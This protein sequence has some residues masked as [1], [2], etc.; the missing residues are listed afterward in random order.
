[1]LLQTIQEVQSTQLIMREDMQNQFSFIA[2][3]MEGMA[4]KDDLQVVKEELQGEIKE[5]E[6]HV[7]AAVEHKRYDDNGITNDRFI[8]HDQRIHA[9]EV[10]TGLS[11]K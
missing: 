11:V 4:T 8:G 1:M 3:C 5:S 6:K 10:H 9:L 7:L 2:E